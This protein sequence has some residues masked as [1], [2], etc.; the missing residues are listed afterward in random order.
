MKNREKTLFRHTLKMEYWHDRKGIRGGFLLL[1][2]AFVLGSVLL[3]GTAC[4]V[5]LK[6][7]SALDE[8]VIRLED[9]FDGLERNGAYVLG[10]APQPGDQ[11]VLDARTLQ[12]VAMALD[13]PWR[14]QSPAEQIVLHRP[15]TLIHSDAVIQTLHPLLE[16]KGVNSRF[17]VDF[18]GDPTIVLPQEIPAELAVANFEFD[19]DRDRFSADLVAPSLDRP[20]VRKSITGRIE[21]I[22][23]VPVLK[24]TLRNGTIIGAHDIEWIDIDLRKLDESTL[25]EADA[26]I[27]MTP[28]RMVMNGRPVKNMDIEAPRIVERGDLVIINLRAGGMVLTAEGKAMQ[29]GA[30]GEVIRVVNTASSRSVEAVVTGGRAVSVQ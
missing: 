4:A 27:G 9:L 26:L 7:S 21:R 1:L 17:Y 10:P 13:V 5:T 6:T 19:A 18:D 23:S 14:P 12:R 30:R 20:L 29:A 22:V 28:R 8:N 24:E 2:A 16:E 11:M 25:L 15:A 3:P